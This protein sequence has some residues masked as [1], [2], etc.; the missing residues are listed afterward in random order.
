MVRN[1]PHKVVAN[2]NS[3]SNRKR[4]CGKP[5]WCEELTELWN[6]ACAAE[7]KWL[8]FSC[9]YWKETKQNAV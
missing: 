9:P 3:I 2:S 8:S 7:K 4:R 6:T 1:I 5:W